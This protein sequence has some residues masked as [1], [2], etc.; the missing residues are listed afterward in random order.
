MKL[1][2]K[3]LTEA[4]ERGLSFSCEGEGEI[5]Y[6]GNDVRKALDAVEAVDEE[7]IYFMDDDAMVGWALIVPGLSDEEWIVDCSGFVGRW[8]DDNA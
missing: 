5:D 7:E 1:L 2:N 8:M 6:R 4:A 3:L